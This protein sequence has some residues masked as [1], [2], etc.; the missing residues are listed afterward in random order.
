MRV[1]LVNNGRHELVSSYSPHNQNYPLENFQ[2]GELIFDQTDKS[3][4]SPVTVNHQQSWTAATPLNAV[5]E[6]YSRYV[7]S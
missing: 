6:D 2:A 3:L 7:P 1:F 5:R 4:V